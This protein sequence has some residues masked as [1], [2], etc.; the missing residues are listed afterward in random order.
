M[1]S[2]WLPSFTYHIHTPEKIRIFPP[3]IPPNTR[4]PLDKQPGFR[5]NK[6]YKTDT[7]P[8]FRKK[9]SFRR[10]KAMVVWMKR[11][12]VL[13][14]DSGSVGTESAA[15]RSALE[16]FGY[17]VTVYYIGR[18]QDYVDVF[19]GNETFEYDY[20]IIGCHGDEGRIMMPIL[21]DEVYYPDECRGDLGFEELRDRVRIQGKTV[22]CT[23]CTTGSGE[24]Y[25]AFTRRNN[26][27]I[28]PSDYIEGKSGL[29]FVIRLFYHLA[30]HVSLEDSCAL[31]C[32]TDEETGLYRLYPPTTL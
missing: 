14:L 10:A 31:A 28:A 26:A 3:H 20:L 11:K 18:P 30:N 19:S 23:G 4:I 21:G 7:P 12:R 1:G 25:R 32:G 2:G 27:F 8:Y 13:I 9:G 15:I 16:C 6:R 22:I 24:L 5:Y 17:V 29:F